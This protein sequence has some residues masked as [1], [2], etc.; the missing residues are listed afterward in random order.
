MNRGLSILARSLSRPAS[1]FA[2]GNSWQYHPRSDRHSKILC[3]AI[4]FD[5]LQRDSA[6]SRG[7]HAEKIAFGINHTM[8]DFQHDRKKDLDLVICRRGPRVRA[9]SHGASIAN[10]ADMADA[11]AVELTSEERAILAG[12]PDIPLSGVQ[13]TLVALEA[14]AAMTEFAKARPRLYDE[15]NSSHLTVHGDTDSAIAAAFI[16]VNSAT[17]FV[18]PLRTPYHVDA[19][20]PAPVTKHV[21]PKSAQTVLDKMQQ[22]PRRS[23]E[24]SAGFDAVGIALIDCRNDGLTPVSLSTAPPAPQPGDA[25]H[26]DTFLE[27]IETIY[28]ARFAGI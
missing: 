20:H 9:D 19:K 1:G 24:R 18:S 4:L 28:A 10:F 8:R 3:W 14:K 16:L 21:Q 6:V 13:T 2:H 23:A 7:F 25:F 12:F 17:S 22:L 11:F 26:Y 5:L 27:R 15:L